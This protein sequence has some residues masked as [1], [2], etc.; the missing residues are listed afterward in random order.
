VQSKGLQQINITFS[1]NGGFTM[2]LTAV[3]GS[4]WQSR[5]MKL[6]KELI[7]I[8]QQHGSIP[9]AVAGD[10]NIVKFSDGKVGGRALSYRNLQDFNECLNTCSLSDIRS[11]GG[12]WTWNNKV[13]GTRRIAGRLD[14]VVCNEMWIDSLPNSFYRYLNHYTSDHSPMLLHTLPCYCI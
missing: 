2:L 10:F 11:S 3:Y 8:H 6:W 14:R 5:S 4:N 7:N 1:N 9:W 12:I 13:M